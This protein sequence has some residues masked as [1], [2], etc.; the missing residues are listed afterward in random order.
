MVS[1]LT[2]V[3]AFLY[4]KFGGEH[5]MGWITPH[6]LFSLSWDEWGSIAAILIVTVGIIRWVI[7]KLDI[8]LARLDEN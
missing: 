3:G 6:S 2:S 7:K 4:L 5:E 8:E 1:A